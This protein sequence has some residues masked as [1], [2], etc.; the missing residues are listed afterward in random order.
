MNK[1]GVNNLVDGNE[2]N[3][4]H[5]TQLVGK[6]YTEIACQVFMQISQRT[7]L[8]LAYQFG[9]SKVIVY[10][11]FRLL[12]TQFFLRLGESSLA[13]DIIN[14]LALHIW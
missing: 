10:D 8:F 4:Y 3:I 7:F 13:G 11:V 14:I 5:C 2:L 6:S 12:F 1:L 9:V